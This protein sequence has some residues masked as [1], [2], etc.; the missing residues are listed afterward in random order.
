MTTSGLSD[1]MRCNVMINFKLFF[2]TPLPYFLSGH[3]YFKHVAEKVVCGT[4]TWVANLPYV[5]TIL[6]I[7]A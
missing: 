1:E 6:R 2:V 5:K 4:Y 3:Q 7:T